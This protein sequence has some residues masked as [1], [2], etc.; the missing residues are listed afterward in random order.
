MSPINSCSPRAGRRPVLLRLLGVPLIAITY[1][2]SGCTSLVPRGSAAIPLQNGV[3]EYMNPSFDTRIN[4]LG[5]ACISAMTAAGA[6]Q[7]YKSDLALR[8]TGWERHSEALPAGNA[9][10]GALAGLASSLALTWI[11]GG[12]APQVTTDNA[13]EWLEKFDDRMEMVPAG[14][15]YPGLPLRK[16]RATAR[17]AGDALDI[18]APDGERLACRAITGG[19]PG[20]HHS[21]TPVSAD[22]YETR[23]DEF[24]PE[25]FPNRLA[26][27]LDR[28]YSPRYSH[29]M[30]NMNK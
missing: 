13:A 17:T 4:W 25:Y 15:S 12:D 21:K 29:I 7:G 30:Q 5:W 26:T 2:F 14:V 16:I 20:S 9:A 23:Y 19:T 3:I 18:H 11:V 10:L 27:A 1:L 22:I 24:T 6:Y 28:A 8:W